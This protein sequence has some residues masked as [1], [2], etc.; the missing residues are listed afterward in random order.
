MRAMRLERP[1]GVETRPLAAVDLPEPEPG[2]G[3]IRVRVRACGVCRTDLHVVEGDLPPVRSPLTPGH[4]IVG[5]VDRVG[6]RASRFRSGDRVGIA[7]L[8]STCGRCAECTRGEENLCA[9]S[10]YTGYHEDGGFAELAVVRAEFAYRIPEVFTD[11]EAAPLLCAGIIGYRALRRTEV[12]PGGRLGL[13]G[14][15]SSAH[16]T[17][18]IARHEGSEVYVFTR[19]EGHRRLAQE[20]GAVWTGG[21]LDASPA[22]LDG[23]I[24][25]APSG[26]L[27]PIA[28]RALRRGGTLA[29]PAIHLTPIPGMT[30]EEHI[31]HEK[32]LTS[33]E[34]NTRRDGEALLRAA[35]AIPI[36]PRT[37]P[38]PLEEANDALAAM[39]RG[40]IDGTAVL[41]MS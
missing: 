2:A 17:I 12:A 4:Q 38:F 23:A 14:F 1:G 16:V 27:V 40:A 5:I 30:Y 9:R 22:P 24:L 41:V 13:F 34:A 19:G 25:F 35:G 18:Q 33:V 11:E 29:I 21:P 6:E 15:G 37:R 28:L 10:C 39:K 32:R 7:W 3:E 26:D 8:R 31:F 36:R 20:L